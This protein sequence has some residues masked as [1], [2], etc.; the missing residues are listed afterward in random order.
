MKI[1][2]IQIN[3]FDGGKAFDKRLAGSNEFGA[4]EN[5]DVRSTPSLLTP[6]R[7]YESDEGY[8]GD[9]DGIKTSDLAL[10]AIPLGGQV[11]A[12]GRKNDGTG[13]KIYRKSINDS[14]WVD[15]TASDGSDAESSSGSAVPGFFIQQFDS[16]GQSIYWFVTG[17]ASTPSTSFWTIGQASFLTITSANFGAKTL[18]FNPTIYPQGILGQHGNVYVSSGRSLHRCLPTG[19][20]TSNA[21]TVSGNFTITSLALYG[22]YLAI[23]IYGQGRSK[24]L[25]WDYASANASEVIEWG[26]GALMVLENLDG[27]LVGVTDKYINSSLFGQ[28]AIGS[29]RMQI[30]MW[31]GSLNTITEVKAFGSAARA[32]EQYKYVKNSVL[33]WYAKIPLEDGS[34]EEGIWSFGSILSSQPNA[35]ALERTLP[36]T[37]EGFWGVGELLYLPHSGDG[38]VSRTNNSASFTLTSSYETA[39]LNGGDS[40]LEKTALGV[41]VSFEALASGETVVLEYRKDGGDWET[42]TPAPAIAEGDISA[43]YPMEGSF[44]EIEFRIETV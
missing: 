22:S 31:S 37:F 32:V 36:G 18:A 17:H 10:F 41:T 38:S 15:F 5:Y 30:K 3:R 16:S 9:A 6:V 12:I 29:G 40:S 20:I 27:A 4:S 34:F 11:Y 23:A 26:E 35:I 42:L 39:L 33:Y 44:K 14:E 13:R 19:S 2:S 24:V 43:L 21:F 7:D 25:L 28:Q 8:D 1:K